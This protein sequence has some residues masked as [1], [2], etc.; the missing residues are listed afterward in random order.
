MIHNYPKIGHM[1]ISRSIERLL[2]SRVR[3]LVL[4]ASLGCVIH[5]VTNTID[6]YRV[7]GKVNN[8]TIEFII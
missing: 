1:Y 5:R 6:G 2:I 8:N 3:I 7:S 4:Y